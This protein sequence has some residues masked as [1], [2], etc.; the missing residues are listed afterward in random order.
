MEKADNIDKSSSIYPNKSSL[1]DIDSMHLPGSRN[2]PKHE[3]ETA[4]I[5][6]VDGKWF[7][8]SDER[9]IMLRGVNLSGNT[10]LPA[11]PY[12]PS[13]CPE[14]FFEHRDISFVDRPFPLAQA[15]EHFQRLHSWGFRFL[16]FLTTWE[17]IEHFGPRKYDYEYFAYV[18]KILQKAKQYGF[19][20]FID[21]HQDVWSRFTG[22]SG[23]P[24][25][26]LELC[27]FDIT[28][29]SET[30]AALQHNTYPDP[31]N[32]P[33]MIWPTNYYKLAC[34]TM[35]TCFFGGSVFAPKCKVVVDH[36][37][38]DNDEMIIVDE[39][40]KLED[41]NNNSGKSVMN[42]QSYL[43]GHY[44]NSVK[45][46]AKYI[47]EN[48]PSL[49]DTVVCGYDTLNE[50]S[51]GFI[52]IEDISS[53]PTEAELRVGVMPTPLEAMLLGQGIT[54]DVS[55]WHFGLLGPQRRGSR[56]VNE[57]G[58]SCWRDGYSCIWEAH[59][60]YDKK[61]KQALKPHYFYSLPGQSSK[62]V[63]WISEFWKPFVEK[64][65][66]S[67]RSV[68]TKAIIFLE[69][70]VN[71]A[72]PIWDAIVGSSSSRKESKSTFSLSPSLVNTGE[73]RICYTPHW[74]DGITLLN[75]S[76]SS[77]FTAD[78]VGYKRGKYRNILEALSFGIRGI[79]SNFARQLDTIKQEGLAFVGD[80]PCLMGEFGIP[81]DM[82]NKAA[83]SSGSYKR[84][85]LAMDANM[86]AMERNLMNFTI[87]N[88]CPDNSH[89]WGDNWNGEDLSIW[90]RDDMDGSRDEFA[91]VKGADDEK[92]FFPAKKVDLN[93]GAR[94]LEAFSRPYAIKTAGTPMEISFDLY[95]RAKTFHYRFKSVSNLSA[96]KW[97]GKHSYAPT[98]IFVPRLHFGRPV[99]ERFSSNFL[100]EH[101]DSIPFA[102]SKSS[103]DLKGLKHGRYISILSR[104]RHSLVSSDD[105]SQANLEFGESDSDM[106]YFTVSVTDG[107]WTYDEDDQILRYYHTDVHKS[108]DER[109]SVHE[110]IIKVASKSKI[111]RALAASG[112][113]LKPGISNASSTLNKDKSSSSSSSRNS[114]WKSKFCAIL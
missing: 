17:A 52:G 95:T 48:D 57:K 45:N 26:T 96:G 64:F 98:E 72:P 22:G 102:G 73:S 71:E 12:M 33:R 76:F 14:K 51:G 15:D 103:L 111:R 8:D 82:D 10:K 75:K 101:H 100:E 5:L 79:R 41:L 7:R 39:H 44:I 70:P 50:P 23:A 66:S 32:F 19:K 80:F 30:G 61:S 28:Q 29:F 84:Q 35:F 68:H 112:S 11:H 92:K 69:P 58:V 46:L 16:R 1:S 60:V 67:L 86:V 42:I 27:G 24:G 38:S 94:A 87:W 105:G 93:D 37:N 89:K 83:Y 78:Y 106:L 9:A 109:F 56:T 81:Y 21:P 49:E 108:S 40:I 63:D 110:I 74:Y 97:R 18:V 62:H 34:A 113:R 25:W 104:S 107:F 43:Q 90:S 65:T 77:L 20:C 114:V 31:E 54:C 47:I 91:H 99:E 53:L 85:I 6:I 3:K 55:F 2:I 36:K 88:Y 4:E 13:H 59:G